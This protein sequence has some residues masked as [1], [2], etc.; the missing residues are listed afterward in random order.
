M[1]EH[2]KLCIHTILLISNEVPSVFADPLFGKRVVILINL[3][4]DHISGPS[5]MKI[6][7]KGGNTREYGWDPKGF[8]M[9]CLTIYLNLSVNIISKNNV[10]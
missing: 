2:A 10:Y 9:K 7:V 6:N 4:I 8:L 3:C 1:F 5:A